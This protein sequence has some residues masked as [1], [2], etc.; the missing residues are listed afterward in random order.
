M[1]VHGEWLQ[2]DEGRTLLLRGVNLGGSSK[3]PAVPDG[4]TWQSHGFYDWRDV[5]FVGRPFP[6][7]DADEHFGHLA[8]WGLRFVRLIVTWEAVEH[9]GPGEYDRAYLDY[10]RALVDAARRHGLEILV[11]PHQD[12]WSRWT[13]G[14]GAPAWTL[15]EAG[16]RLE[17]LHASGAALLHQESGHPYPRMIWPTNYNRLACAT[18][19]TLF[20]GGEELAPGICILG[21]PAQELLQ[22][23][24]L[25]AMCEVARALRRLPNVAGF[26]A[27]N[28]PSLGF[29]GLR[30]IR[31]LERASM[32]KGLMPSPLETMGAGS[33]LR[34]RCERWRLGL[35]GERRA[36]RAELN[37]TGARAW[38]S[39]RECI[40][41][42]LGVWENRSGSP[43]ARRPDH[44]RVVHD[45]GDRYLKPFQTRFA[46]EL[47]RVLPDAILFSESPPAEQQLRW[48]SG[49]AGPVVNSPHWYDGVTL[50][51]KRYQELFTV[52]PRSRKLFLGPRGVRRCFAEHLATLREE[53]R[54]AGGAPTLI[55]EFGLPFDMDRRR[56]YRTGSFRTHERALSRY[57]DALDA[58]LL[59]ATIWNYTADNDNR[60]GDQW[61][62]EDLSI[63]SR[64]Q[65]GPRA[66]RGFCRPYA[67]RTAGVPVSMSFDAARHRFELRFVLHPA[68]AAPTV[69]YIP[70]AQYPGGY[71]VEITGDPTLRT[72]REPAGQ[73]LLLFAASGGSCAGTVTVVVRPPDRRG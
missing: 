41:Q 70:R 27:M 22:G 73:R 35:T 12:V 8:S 10:L 49:E 30:D 21:E 28:E 60:H 14:D 17:S 48:G 3:V 38:A 58:N 44:F 72:E 6:L 42:R 55:G 1:R 15:L 64:D 52:D 4:A 24:Y 62:D 39:G 31:R 37:P 61:N 67:E 47:R 56:A 59:G 65:G 19:F 36:G 43:V 25:A 33:G 63:Y 71:A 5:S 7:A 20:Y 66:L 68:I 18:M 34:L 11:D 54:T 13:G 46:T 69:I 51:T 53:G 16:F 57:Y 50:V 29:I 45:P 9:A 32:R 2:D 40:W 26:G 23:R